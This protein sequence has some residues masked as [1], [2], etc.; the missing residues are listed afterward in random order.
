MS[1]EN[2][3]ISLRMLYVGRKLPHNVLDKFAHHAAPPL[4]KLGTAKIHGWVGGRHLLDLPITE[5]NAY[6]GGYL[7][8]VLMEAERK[9]PTSLLRAECM[10]EEV[11]WLSEEG[12]PFIDRKSRAQIRKEVLQRL[13][14]QMPPTLKGIAFVYDER[15]SVLYT[16]ATSDKQLDAFR[17]N[18][19]S[20]TGLDLIP[21]L[22]DTTAAQRRRVN[23]LEWTKTS[24][25]PEVPDADVEHTPGLD[26]LT[27]LW[28][29]SEA[30][31]GIFTSTALGEIGVGLE[32]P[33]LFLRA[34]DGAHETALRKGLPTVS[35]EAKTALLSGKKLRRAKILIAVADQAWSCGF[36]AETFVFRGLKLPEPKEVLDPASRFQDRIQ[37]IGEFREVFFTLFDR[38]LD[39][40]CDPKK[41]AATRKQIQQWAADR[42]TRK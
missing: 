4:P 1:F 6:Y 14:P 11:A 32:G 30:R 34:G 10:L 40:R 8:L 19:H 24:F 9:V 3:S 12:K 22:A 20:T 39:D 17:I 35:A 28:F 29:A 5:A 16:G 13:L 27:W 38:F 41:W 15:A 21:F 36:D 42:T 31:G 37:K 2:G 18:F 7:R 33:L 26:F 25:S 23:A